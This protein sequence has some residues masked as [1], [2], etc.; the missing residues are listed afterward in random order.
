TFVNLDNGVDNDNNGVSQPALAGTALNSVVFNLSGCEID[1]T[2]DVALRACPVIAF[3]PISLPALTQYTPTSTT[4]TATGGVNPYLWTVPSGS[5]PAGLTLASS[6]ATTA[7]VAG[8]PTSAPGN[9]AATLRARDSLGCLVD[10][11]YSITVNC[12]VITINNPGLADATQYAAYSQTLTAT[13]N[14]TGVPAQ[15]YVWSIAGG[16]LPA[17]LSLNPSTG[18]I[19]GTPSAAAVPGDFAITVKVQDVN[20]CAATKGFTLV[21]NCPPITVTGNPGPATQDTPYTTTFTAAGGTAP[22][23]WAVVTGTLPTGLVLTSS[24]ATTATIS[25]TPTVVQSAS[26]T[27]KATDVNG[28]TV[29]HGY[30]IAVGCPIIT[31]SPPSP[32]AHVIQYTAMSAVN[33]TAVGGRTPYTWSID[34]ATPLPAGLVF[35][36]SSASLNGTPTAAPGVYTFNV[37]LVDNSGCPGSQGYSITIDCP[38]VTITTPTPLPDGTVG[39][40]YSQALAAVVSGT[41]VPVQS[42]LWSV[43][44][45]T[46]PGGLSLNGSTGVISGTPTV[47][48]S[49]TVTLRATNGQG[50][51]GTK[52]VTITTICPVVSISPATMATGYVG[53]AYSQPFTASGGTSPYT[54][55]VIAGVMPS[56]LSLNTNTGV[57]SGTPTAT[58]T[59]SL[60]LEATDR[61]GCKG[62][63]I[64]SLVIKTMGIGNLVWDDCNNNAIR[65][66][67]E[68]GLAGAVVQL[69]RSGADNLVNTADDVAVGSSFTTSASGT[70]NF[71]NIPPGNYY[72]KVNPPA[73]WRLTGGTP[74]TSDNRVDNDNNGSQPA[75]ANTPAYSPIINLADAAEPSNDGDSDT[76]TDWTVDFGFW[77][78]F[79]VGNLVWNDLNSDGI[80]QSVSEAGVAGITVELVN[81]GS[82][83]AVGG[84][85]GA[86]D[87][88]V[89]TTTT[90]SFGLYSFSVLAA[91]NY[92]VRVTPTALYPMVSGSPVSLDNGVDNDNN[93]TQ[94]GGYLAVINSMVFNLAACKEAGSSGTTNVE[95]TID[96][97]LRECPP[98]VLSPTTVPA[99]TQ[100]QPFSQLFTASAGTAP[101]S[102]TVISG[103]LPTGLT[104]TTTSSTTCTISGNPTATPGTYNIT[105]R[106]IDVNGCRLDQPL[107]VTVNCPLI[108]INNAS[109]PSGTQYV[110]YSTTL[111]ATTSGTGVPAQSY[112]WSISS[113]ALPPGITINSSSGIISGTPSASAMPGNYNFTA[114]VQDIGGCFTTKGFTLVLA[115][116]TVTMAPATLPAPTEFTAYSTTLNAS[117]GT[118]PYTWAVAGTLPAGLSLGSS[119]GTISGT[120]TAIESRTF[121]VRATDVNGCLVEK[122]YTLAVGCPVI[123]I[124]PASL[125]TITQYNAMTPVVFTAT[126][127][128][129]PYNFSIDSATPLPAGLSFNAGTATLSGTTTVAPGNY[130]INIKLVDNSGCPGS[131]AYTLTVVCP[132]VNITPASLPSGTVGTAYSQSLTATLSGTAVPAQTWNWSLDTG[133]LPAGLSLSASTGVIS[134]TPTAAAS[135][136]VTVRATNTQGCT[137]TASYSIN[138]VCPTI[139]INPAS[140][141]TAFVNGA[142]SQTI[143]ASGGNSP[144]TFAITSGTLPA[145]LSFDTNAGVISGTPSAT[146]S[147]TLVIRA[148]DRYNCTASISYPFNVKTMGIGNLVFS[149]CNNN[150]IFDAGDT[151]L[152]GASVQLFRP[153]TD[154][155]VNTADDVQ[156]GGTQVTSSSGAYAFTNIPPGT[157]FVKVTPPSTHLKTGGTPVTLDNNVDNDNNGAQSALGA[158]LFSPLIALTENGESITDG[159]T[160]PNTNLTVDFGLY[161]GV[162]VGNL[163]WNDVNNNGIKDASESGIS[164]LTVQ[165]MNP[166]SDN[167]VGG[168]STAADTVVATT[169]TASDGSY[170]FQFYTPGNYFIAVVPGPTYV[171]PS[172]VAVSIDNGVDNDSNAVSQPGFAGTIINTMIF[173]LTNCEV[174]NTIDLGLRACPTIT[175]TPAT[176]AAVTQYTASSTTL[177]A[178]GGTAPYLWTVQS[179]SLPAGLSMTS[180]GTISG[181]PTAVPGTYNVTI[182]T[183]DALGCRLDTAYPITVLCPV[184]TINNA[185]LANATQYVAYSQTLTAT[186]SGTTVP[187]QVYTWSLAS[188]VLPDGL[189]LNPTTGVISGTPTGVSAPGG[190][191]LSIKVQDATGCSATKGFTLLL[192]CPPVIIAGSVADTTQ[193]AT[194]SA[195]LT[196]SGGTAPYT[197]QVLTGALPTGLTLT[198]SGPS[199]VSL[200]GV[201]TV[202]QSATFTIRATDKNGCTGDATYTIAVGCPVITIS[203]DS[204][205]PPATEYAAM[206]PVVFS[207]V[208]GRTPYQWFIDSTTPLPAGL[209]FNPATATLSGT[210]TAAPGAYN[211]NVRLTDNSG[212]PGGRGY[213]LVINCPPIT[214]TPSTIPNGVVGT[215]YSQTFIA[216]M[217]GTNVPAQVWN[218]SLQSG[219]M[220]AGLSLNSSTGV[221]SG[222]PTAPAV[223]ST[224]TVQASNGQ[225][226]AGTQNYTFSITC[227]TISISPASF[228]VAAQYAPGYSQTLNASGGSAPYTWSLTSG[229]LPTGLNFNSATGLLSGTITNP[230]TTATLV[231]TASDRYGCS[232]TRSYQLQVVAVDYGDLASLPSA[233]SIIDSSIKMGTAV[234]DAD[235]PGVTNAT[236]TAD[237]ASGV[238]D[239]DGVIFSPMTQGL[240]SVITVKVTNNSGAPAY[241]NGWIDFNGNGTMEAGEQVANNMVIATGTTAANTDITLTVPVDAFIGNIGARFRLTSTG[242]P[243]VG[244][245]SGSGEVEDYR[246]PICAPQPCGKTFISQN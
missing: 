237:D 97:G 178:S 36:P 184:I 156:V 161:S 169:T 187:P 113:G 148:T 53:G 142:Y 24:T 227:P 30:T 50:C 203:P 37:K 103:T 110:A 42:W 222:T 82:D 123:T 234:T 131:K 241:L 183:V 214:I 51:F 116:P 189:S 98:L 67:G 195:T 118:A 135:S 210:P 6:D 22:Y 73:G 245:V 70:Y 231:F 211:F 88:V 68:T 91:G 160:D 11:S 60:T 7:T 176:F 230:P 3:T 162:R 86:A 108:T 43:D 32:L 136:T 197:W 196:A 145:G 224:I 154:N 74:V 192:D 125:A 215:P 49:A 168:T 114:K 26:F 155:L 175:I 157:Y 52:A 121:T 76:N 20:G 193:D 239:E 61:Y 19:S 171:L 119:S 101:Y 235:A 174:D 212:C 242:S 25:G 153:G 15:V 8:N 96:I 218:W 33:F 55:A 93:G 149:D 89:V 66:A 152:A 151:G 185:T 120:P 200:A 163:V 75:G 166:G 1:N 181:T 47:A 71:T 198:S 13:T 58:G 63:A 56:G 77:T 79:T 83:N 158:P 159:D 204:P 10:Q 207:A 31:I 133:T 21:V 134:G 107:A 233:S 28:C 129:A 236:A 5:L 177:T 48:T 186:T 4:F 228:A 95:N 64:Y 172:S 219:V 112:V 132:P 146:A 150:G 62:S 130:P 105:L 199:T 40:F 240:V 144:Y 109:V 205:L 246:V 45:G 201:P 209:T 72:V 167:A 124:N 16:T 170:G 164:G 127:G 54:W 143:T 84:S 34:S 165:L 180:S 221:L 244:G 100:Y 122:A 115:C 12:P 2:I 208:G 220:P 23:A 141:P 17:G 104:L 41:G 139:A 94:P 39:T 126:G 223:S 78:G 14:G 138:M 18:V 102:F 225:G 147:T 29:N 117:G 87:S 226:C 80:Y 81:P 90:D 216:S 202:V 38:T 137:G 232:A 229:T 213:Q 140:L 85:G 179:G 44:A 106:V 191:P 182:R 92:Y 194:Y 46:L 206:T 188:G 59:A 35:T 190:F 27:L 69:Y 111:T 217:A 128:N 9:Y 57:I 173:A 65:D 99:A 243:G 238:D